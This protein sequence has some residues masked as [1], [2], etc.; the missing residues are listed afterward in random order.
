MEGLV[1]IGEIEI[2]LICDSMGMHYKLF[3]SIPVVSVTPA[4]FFVYVYT[5][6]T[7]KICTVELFGSESILTENKLYSPKKPA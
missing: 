2:T 3:Y 6:L 5:L 7:V 4:L 1:Q